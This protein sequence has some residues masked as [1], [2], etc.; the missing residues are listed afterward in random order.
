MTVNVRTNQN[1]FRGFAAE[2]NS[3]TLPLAPHENSRFRLVLA[4]VS[5]LA[6]FD[7][8]VILTTDRHLFAARL[9]ATAPPPEFC[10]HLT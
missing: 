8:R 7:C 1:V 10:G 3:L 4:L 2:S 9:P 5:N 6:I